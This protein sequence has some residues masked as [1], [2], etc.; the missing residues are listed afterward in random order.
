[1]ATER[2]FT[3][4]TIPTADHT[5]LTQSVLDLA[6]L[7]VSVHEVLLGLNTET[8][9]LQQIR[10]ARYNLAKALD[11]SLSDSPPSSLPTPPPPLRP[12]P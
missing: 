1:V 6:Q 5:A 11:L 2:D 7:R 10:D 4:K 12:V 3:W 9:T 8:Y